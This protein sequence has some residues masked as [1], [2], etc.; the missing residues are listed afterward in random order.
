MLSGPAGG[1]WR[2]KRLFTKPMSICFGVQG[3]S[4]MILGAK[5]MFSG[6]LTPVPLDRNQNIFFSYRKKIP[7]FFVV[8]ILGN[9][10][11]IRPN[12]RGNQDLQNFDFQNLVD[13]PENFPKF[14]KKIGFFFR[15]DFLKNLTII[16]CSG[17]LHIINSYDLLMVPNDS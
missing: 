7:K 17:L 13:F 14:Q 16:F 1:I 12:F 6:C 15:D 8:E 11:G 5:N 2:P 10:R 9:F 3:A 4:E